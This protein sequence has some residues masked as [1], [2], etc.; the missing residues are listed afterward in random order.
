MPDD[1]TL[2]STDTIIRSPA[3]NAPSS[4]SASLRRAESCF[5][6]SRTRSS[7]RGKRPA[8]QGLSPLKQL[9]GAKFK[10]RR[11]HRVDRGEHPSDRARPGIGVIRQK[12][13]MALCDMQDD[14]PCLEQGEIAFLIGRDLAERMKSQMRG[15]LHRAK[16]NK[17]NLVGFAHLLKRP[18]NARITR[19][20][21]AA[22]G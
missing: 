18:A 15:L 12:T 2:S 21:P 22:I 11:L 13:R 6:R 20:S 17:A 16:R 14:R 19:Q 10:D 9:G 8:C 7:T 3:L 1:F 5:S 4:Q